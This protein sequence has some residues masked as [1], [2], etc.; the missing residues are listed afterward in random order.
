MY[1]HLNGRAFFVLCTMAHVQ[2]M[3]G[4][5]RKE[6]GKDIHLGIMT[7]RHYFPVY[8]FEGYKYL[9]PW[10]IPAICSPRT[11]R[12]FSTSNLPS[13]IFPNSDPTVFS[14][15]QRLPNL[16]ILRGTSDKSSVKFVGKSI[17]PFLS[18]QTDLHSGKSLHLISCTGEKESLP[19]CLTP[20]PNDSQAQCNKCLQVAGPWPRA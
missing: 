1:V 18:M 14:T 7:G 16:Q 8:V 6:G 17:P 15:S 12:L 19:T 13:S 20:L 5:G 4:K 10:E 2:L 3:P 11:W 9:A